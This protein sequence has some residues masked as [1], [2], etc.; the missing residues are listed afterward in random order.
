MSMLEPYA[1]AR[2]GE[3]L[4]DVLT[5]LV[6]DIRRALIQMEVPV[7]AKLAHVS[8]IVDAAD[9][10]PAGRPGRKAGG[11]GELAATVSAMTR[12]PAPP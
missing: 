3:G 12:S 11:A 8:A 1:G 6:I 7:A 10:L 5:T 9:T 4:A 2:P